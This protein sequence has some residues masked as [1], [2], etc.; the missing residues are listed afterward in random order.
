M[1]IDRLV[2]RPRH[3]AVAGQGAAFC[4]M[5]G[6]VPATHA[7]PL[8]TPGMARVNTPGMAR[9]AMTRREELRS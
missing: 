5:T 4:V 9:E 2:A 6:S 8:N 7:F 1:D 3:G